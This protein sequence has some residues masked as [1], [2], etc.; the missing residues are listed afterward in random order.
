MN[1]ELNRL[2]FLPW[3]YCSTSICR[4]IGPSFLLSYVFCCM[5]VIFTP[6]LML[7][8]TDV[9][10]LDL[11]PT[12]L[13]ACCDLC[14]SILEHSESHYKQLT[15]HHGQCEIIF[16]STKQVF[17]SVFVNPQGNCFFTSKLPY[18]LYFTL[19]N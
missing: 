5:L 3:T 17:S 4:T 19:L 13:Q 7:S 14:L 8:T 9:V 10:E 11:W 2:L 1:N 6:W 12:V 18:P 15:S 16:H